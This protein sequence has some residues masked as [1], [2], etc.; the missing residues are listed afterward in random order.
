MVA[1]QNLV[2]G[3]LSVLYFHHFDEA[4]HFVRSF[5]RIML[6]VIRHLMIRLKIFAPK[7]I[8]L[9]T[10]FVNVKMNIAFLKI[11]CAGL[12]NDCFGVKS[13]NCKPRTIS[14]ALS[15]LLG[16]NE[17]NLKLVMVRFFV[18]DEVIV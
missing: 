13:L 17:K 1:R 15:M 5:V 9:K 11:R 4:E 8:Y 14:D 16:R 18:D 7:L 2:C 3:R 10:T 6:V 12:P